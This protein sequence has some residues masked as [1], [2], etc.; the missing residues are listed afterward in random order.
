[1]LKNKDKA[2]LW[3]TFWKVKPMYSL[4]VLNSQ[5]K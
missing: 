5:S 3:K 2:I 4:V 1:M